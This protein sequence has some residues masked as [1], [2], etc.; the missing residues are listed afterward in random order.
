M[1]AKRSVGRKIWD[2]VKHITI[3]VAMTPVYVGLA[4]IN[5][6][7]GAVISIGVNVFTSLVTIGAWQMCHLV[8][9]FTGTPSYA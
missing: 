3:M 8:K 9:A 4:L 2:F 5:M 6:F 1:Q 7:I